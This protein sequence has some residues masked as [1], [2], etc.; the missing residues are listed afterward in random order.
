M[1]FHEDEPCV[2]PPLG[3]NEDQV[4]AHTLI[5]A[6]GVKKF[7]DTEKECV[8]A[9]GTANAAMK[10]TQPLGA[11]VDTIE[12]LDWAPMQW[13]K[14]NCGPEV[15]RELGWSYVSVVHTDTAYGT[16]GFAI[17]IESL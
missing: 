4:G 6:I 7:E 14:A 8:R 12:S 5:Q 2:F 15:L 17:C 3:A 13:K 10:R 9:A 1:A 16:T 11:P